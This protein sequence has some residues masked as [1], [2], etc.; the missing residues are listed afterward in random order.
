VWNGTL[1][2]ELERITGKPLSTEAKNA[3]ATY[4]DAWYNSQPDAVKEYINNE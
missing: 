4:R 2:T 3:I 1:Y